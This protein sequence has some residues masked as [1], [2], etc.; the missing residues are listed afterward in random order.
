MGFYILNIV[1]KTHLDNFLFCY[2]IVM[3]N[4][5]KK[6]SFRLLEL[7]QAQKPGPTN[8]KGAEVSLGNSIRRRVGNKRQQYKGKEVTVQPPLFGLR[9]QP[10]V[11]GNCD[12]NLVYRANAGT[13]TDVAR[14]R[15]L[16]GG[17]INTFNSKNCK[18]PEVKCECVPQPLTCPPSH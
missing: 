6:C 3:V 5:R 9:K 2:I 8:L 11:G 15:T 13:G 14:W 18:K 12:D 17:A 10:R 4:T 1:A 16:Y 7:N